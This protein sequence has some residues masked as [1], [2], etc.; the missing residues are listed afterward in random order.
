[1]KVLITGGA[2]FIGH[3]FVEHFLKHTDWQIII[4]D[5]LTYA[6]GGL[7]RL[8]DIDVFDSKRVFVYTL[9]I[10]K[11]IPSGV[12]RETAEVNYILHL[13][14]ETHVDNSIK[15]PRP[16]VQTNVL[17]T[18]EMLQFALCL[19]DLKK[20]FYFSTD[21]V[22]GPALMLDQFQSISITERNHFHTYHEWDRYAS[23]NPYAASKAGGEELC[24]AYY[25]T[26]N[27]PVVITHTMNCFG[28]RQHPEKF[29][30]LVMNA[31]RA[32][33]KTIIHSDPEKKNPG[34]RSY[35][36]CRN[37]AN[38]YHFLLDKAEPGEKYNIV[39]E[40]ELTNLEYATLIAEAMGKKLEYEMVDFHSSRPGHD[41]R[42]ALSGSKMKYMGWVPP[43]T[44]EDSLTKTV[45]WML[46]NPK[47][48]EPY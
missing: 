45:Q 4:F 46:D 36:H 31:V 6:S 29:L 7:D 13:A 41:L 38:A 24:L 37:V 40:K 20:F 33:K 11:P 30:G 25:N 28:E 5:K 23:A 8:R 48:L 47:W 9:D 12:M 17:G 21:E 35:I 16:F 1:M 34:V 27:L 19:D 42:Y 43:K 44:I 3:H 22:Y 10:T 15:N 32:G 14:A 2:G 26:Y 39:G 18:M